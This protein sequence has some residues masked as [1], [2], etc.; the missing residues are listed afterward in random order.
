MEMQWSDYI[1]IK[2]CKH[3]RWDYFGWVNRH[4]WHIVTLILLHAAFP[5]WVEHITSA[6]KD[7][8]SEYTMSCLASGRPKPHI[9]WLK[10]GELVTLKLINLYFI[11]IEQFSLSCKILRASSAALWGLSELLQC[12]AQGCYS[13]TA[14]TG[15]WHSR[16]TSCQEKKRTCCCWAG[17]SMCCVTLHRNN[18]HQA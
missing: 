4:T 12:A 14:V 1:Y 15:N 8:N 5:E 10:N 18:C 2:W 7:L 6:E 9:R 11:I 3:V 13:S 17:A 16:F